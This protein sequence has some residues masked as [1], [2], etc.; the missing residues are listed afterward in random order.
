MGDLGMKAI[1]MAP[2]FRDGKFWGVV[3][4]EDYAGNMQVG[5]DSLDLLRS[6]AGMC[7]GALIR[8]V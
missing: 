6:T 2:V 3:T 7:V 1:F 8:A 5:E 4:F